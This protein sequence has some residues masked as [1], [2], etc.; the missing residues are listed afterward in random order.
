MMNF[1]E[2]VDYFEEGERGILIFLEGVWSME[3]KRRGGSGN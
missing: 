3:G 2:S 1:W